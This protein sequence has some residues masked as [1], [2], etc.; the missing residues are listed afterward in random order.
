MA[1]VVNHDLLAHLN[2]VPCAPRLCSKLALNVWCLVQQTSRQVLAGLCIT[3][4]VTRGSITSSK[5][6]L[7]CEPKLAL[8]Y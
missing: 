4:L 3:L 5:P 8:N 2:P 6:L 1:A 7:V